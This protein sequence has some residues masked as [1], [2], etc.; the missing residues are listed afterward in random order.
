MYKLLF[1][2]IICLFIST[3]SLNA[4]ER[5]YLV[6]DNHSDNLARFESDAPIEKVV[7]TTNNVSGYIELDIYNLTNGISGT[8]TVDLVS[9]N[10]GIAMRDRDM[11]SEQFL[12]TDEY[13]TATFKPLKIVNSDIN[14]LS[15]GKSVKMNV[16]G[17][18][19]VHGITNTVEV[20]ATLKLIQNEGVDA[21]SESQLSEDLSVNASFQIKLGDYSIKRPKFLFLQLAEE[22]DIKVIFRIATESK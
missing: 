14:E 15:T 20:E 9:L 22:V 8:I 1:S 17:D 11:R 13:S 2:A 18:F 4:Q 10:T 6:I 3:V 16:Q 12:N 21:F 7:G 5:Q 19:Q